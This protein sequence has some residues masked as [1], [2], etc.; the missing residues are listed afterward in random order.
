M[1]IFCTASNSGTGWSEK[2]RMWISN[3]I[4][5]ET[6]LCSNSSFPQNHRKYTWIE[7]QF[8]GKGIAVTVCLHILKHGVCRLFYT[9]FAW[10][11]VCLRYQSVYQGM[12]SQSFLQVLEKS[13]LLRKKAVY[14]MTSLAFVF[15]TLMD[16]HAKYR[17]ATTQTHFWQVSIYSHKKED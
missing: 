8:I 1:H 2:E 16:M 14:L 4:D 9:S 7:T 11:T 17:N 10:N 5:S 12:P 3:C 6:E 13:K 15:N